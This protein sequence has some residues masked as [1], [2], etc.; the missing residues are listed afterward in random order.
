MTIKGS[1]SLSLTSDIVGEF[2]GATGKNMGSLRG[3]RWY[4]DNALPTDVFPSTNISFSQFYAKRV[5][6]PAGSGSTSYTPGDYTFVTPLYRN[7][8]TFYAW[9]GGGGSNAGGSGDASTVSLPDTTLTAGGGYSA[10]YGGSRRYVG[11]AGPGGTQ[12]GGQLGENGGNGSGA[13]RGPGGNA[14][15]LAYGGGTGGVNPG[16]NYTAFPGNA[17]GGGGSAT[18]G[19]DG[20]KDPG[21]SGAGG[22]GGAGFSGSTYTPTNLAK[23]TGVNIHVGAAGGNGGAGRVNISWG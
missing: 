18:F 4:V 23:D 20:S 5:T 6:D 14:G 3:T 19:Y 22:A 21:F 9:G 11:P 12:S 2:T 8:I 7:S 1:G 15:G 10:A 13:I 17:P 16:A